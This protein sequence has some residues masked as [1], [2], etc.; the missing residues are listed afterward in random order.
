MPCVSLEKS[1]ERAHFVCAPH[2]DGCIRAKQCM[3]LRILPHKT[4]SVLHSF[5][6]N[7]RRLREKI[8][9]LITKRQ[10]TTVNGQQPLAACF[11]LSSRDARLV[12]TLFIDNPHPATRM[13]PLTVVRWLLSVDRAS[14]KSVVRASENSVD[15]WHKKSHLSIS[16]HWNKLRIF[17]TCNKKK[18]KQVW[19]SL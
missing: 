16:R 11:H 12:R 8:I 1:A 3:P 15:H 18:N 17:A 13:V 6:V 10:L 9:T 4:C 7:L 2:P 14:E 19:Q 5:C